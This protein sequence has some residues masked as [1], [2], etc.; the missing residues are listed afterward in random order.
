MNCVTHLSG[1][2][3]PGD[4]VID[5]GVRRVEIVM[6]SCVHHMAHR[7]GLSGLGSIG[8]NRELENFTSAMYEV[9]EIAIERMRYAANAKS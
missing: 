5:L 2:A 1:R 3:H 4:A 6:G 7:G 8:R 9:C